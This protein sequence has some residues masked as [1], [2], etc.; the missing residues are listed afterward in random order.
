[1]W[2]S[3][4]LARHSWCLRKC[5]N[6]LHQNSCLNLETIAL[7]YLILSMHSVSCQFIAFFFSFVFLLF[8][9]E[10]NAFSSCLF[11][12][13]WSK[14]LEILLFVCQHVVGS[15][16]CWH[17]WMFIYFPLFS[18]TSFRCSEAGVIVTLSAISFLI[19]YLFEDYI[20]NSL[21]ELGSSMLFG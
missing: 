13:A 16:V 3:W 20:D 10:F 11:W 1:M 19:A 4:M 21:Y 15:F 8:G 12:I 17:F 18:N 9:E 14:V 5:T 6:V 7:R 2:Y